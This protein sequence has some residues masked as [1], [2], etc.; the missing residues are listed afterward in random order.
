MPDIPKLLEVAYAAAAKVDEVIFRAAVSD[1]GESRVGTKMFLTISEQF[2]AMLTLIAGGHSS[3][4]P[5][6]VRSM[7]EG[8]ANLVCLAMDPAY[9]DQIRYEDAKSNSILFTE[10][11]AAPDMDPDAIQTLTEWNEKAQSVRKE[12]GAKGFK[13]VDLPKKF[14]QAGI[15][16]NYVA[17]RVF[18]SFAHNQ[19]TTLMARHAGHFELKYQAEAPAELTK[20]ILSVAVS[21]LCR[22]MMNLPKFTNLAENELKAIAD[23]IDAQWTAAT[24]E[25]LAGA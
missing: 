18:C 12:L 5:I 19:L 14:R 8:M 4:S 10:Y 15:A 7:L 22:S 6:L 24:S 25:P 3:Q 11:M 21:I 17:Y 20:G 16:E 9:V 2:A 23:E 1:N 13:P